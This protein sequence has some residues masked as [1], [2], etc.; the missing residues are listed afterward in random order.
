MKKMK[1]KYKVLLVILI[2][3]IV[4]ILVGIG[5]ISS[6]EKSLSELDYVTFADVDLTQAEDGTYNGSY[7]AGPIDVEVNVTIQDN[8]I[9][10]IVLI[11]HQN[12]KGSAADVILNNVVEAQSLQ[13]DA[14]SGATYSSKV[15]LKAIEDALSKAM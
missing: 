7:K 3:I 9:E 15:I 4:L 11:K 1:K 2:I 5:I 14:I 10:E 13:V 8:A 12:G 6:M